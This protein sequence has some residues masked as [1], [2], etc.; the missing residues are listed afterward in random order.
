MSVPDRRASIPL[1]VPRSG[2]LLLLL[3]VKSEPMASLKDKTQRGPWFVRIGGEML[4]CAHERWFS[5]REH[6][7]HD[8]FAEP[9]RREW[10]EWVAALKEKRRAVMTRGNGT[11]AEPTRYLGVYA[12]DAIEVT[13]SD[14]RFRLVKRLDAA[15]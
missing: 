14:L 15:I 9:G 1:A 8:P 13:E 6:T 10:D 2:S 7:Y 12:I 4:P 3:T 11:D 5:T